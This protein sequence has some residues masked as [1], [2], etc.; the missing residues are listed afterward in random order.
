V[1]AGTELARIDDSV[2]QAE[3]ALAQASCQRSQAESQ[4]VQVKLAQAARRREQAQQLVAK[5]NISMSDLDQA[6]CDVEVAKADVAVAEAAIA[7]S[8]AGLDLA[9]KR[10]SST[11]I[12]APVRGVILTRRANVGQMVS[13]EANAPCLFTVAQDRLQ[14]CATFGE[15][16]IGVIRPGQSVSFT[17]PTCPDE[18]FGGK[19]GRICLH[20]TK[21]Q[22]V[23]TYTAV[24]LPDKS[25]PRVLPYLTAHVR[26]EAERRQNVLNVPN[27][28]LRWWPQLEWVAPDIRDQVEQLTHQ[29]L[30]GRRGESGAKAAEAAA[31]KGRVWIPDG[32]SVRPLEVQ[33]GITDGTVTELKGGEV[34]EHMGVVVGNPR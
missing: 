27:T 9:Q 5:N 29:R 19:V 6:Q 26:I 24:I 10:L 8:R 15:N 20:A 34:K 3:V 22:D 32:Q 18:S 2:Y 12:L 21:T 1:E 11:R 4:R 31:K 25:D 7:Q 16:D 14:I 30:S 33:T 13:P 23:V 17:V 28:A